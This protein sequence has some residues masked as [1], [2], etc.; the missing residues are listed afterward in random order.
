MLQKMTQGAVN[1]PGSPS[2]SSFMQRA[3]EDD[4]S[5]LEAY[6]SSV[7]S[8]IGLMQIDTSHVRDDM[9][10]DISDEG[11]RAMQ[12]DPAYEE[13]VL[14]TIRSALSTPDPFASISGGSAIH[15]QFGA[16]REEFRA[17]A[18]RKGSGDIGD[19]TGTGKKKSYWEERAEREE[20]NRELDAKITDARMRAR[21]ANEV[22]RIRGEAT[23]GTEN[24]AAASE[25]I[26]ILLA[27]YMQGM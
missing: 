14:G 1:A 13:W 19:L 23:P 17:N 26:T 3:Q 11:L 8:R 21:A 9:F 12:A 20:A 25:I 7:E 18:G 16:T 5:G 2:F 27:S 24:A 15:F 10:I 4:A 22:K 6:R